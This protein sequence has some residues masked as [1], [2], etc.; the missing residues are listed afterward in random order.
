[1][2]MSDH[3]NR[4]V[5]HSCEL[6]MSHVSLFLLSYH[7][8]ISMISSISDI[9][10]IVDIGYV[11]LNLNV[12]EVRLLIIKSSCSL[13]YNNSS[14]FYLYYSKNSYDYRGASAFSKRA[15]RISYT[16]AYTFYL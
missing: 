7:S 5:T 4:I 16:R 6:E 2:S 10:D 15:P 11:N 13:Y 3:R 12:V 14:T 8:L 9:N 1:M